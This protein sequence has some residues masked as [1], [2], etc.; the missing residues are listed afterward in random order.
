MLAFTHP[1]KVGDMLYAL[2]TVK[3]ICEIK[4][5]PADFWTSEY[6]YPI[7]KRLVERQSYIRKCILSPTYVIEGMDMGVRPA[8][9]PIDYT[10]YETTYHLG[11]R[12]VPDKVLPAFIAR[13]VGSTWNG[14][15]E[16]EYDD[17]ETLDEPYIVLAPRGETSYKS[18]FL[19]LIKKSPIKTVIIGGMGDLIGDGTALNKCGLDLVETL[20]WIAK[21]KGFVGLMSSQ[22]VLANGFNIPKVSP[23]DGIH[24]D[25]NHVIKSDTNFY[26]I[27]PTAEHILELLGI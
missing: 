2:P 13:S 14:K 18:T 5:Q 1:G 19:D 9:V 10:L 15:I 4:K 7:V 12:T 25:M 24:W 6:C 21:S 17:L 8:L 27:N 20:P 26:P 23:H 11:F 16:Y 22:L 3:A